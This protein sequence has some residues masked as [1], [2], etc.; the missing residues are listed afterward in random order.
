MFEGGERL[1]QE[2]VVSRP[3]ID[4]IHAM[5]SFEEDAPPNVM[6]IWSHCIISIFL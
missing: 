1:D 4:P 2:M 5:A 3:R 6:W